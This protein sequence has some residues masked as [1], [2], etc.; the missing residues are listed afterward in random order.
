MKKVLSVML[1]LVML[2]SLFGAFGLTAEAVSVNV[3]YNV[4]LQ[5]TGWQ[6]QKSN[7]STA[8][9]TG[10]SKRIEAIKISVSGLTNGGVMYR[11]YIQNS[12]WQTW[13]TSGSLSGTTGKSLR[14]EAIQI[15]LTGNYA[16][17]YDIVYRVHVQNFGWLSWTK[18]GGTAGTTN[19]SYRMEAIQMKLVKKGSFSTSGSASRTTP[20][21]SYTAHVQDIGW[22]SSKSNGTTAGTTGQAKQMEAIKISCKNFSGKGCIK[23]SAH[24]QDVGWQK[25]VS[26]NT[27]AGTT[28]K[29]KRMEAIKISLDSTMSPYFDVYYRVHISN[30]GWLAWTKNGAIAGSTGISTP[31]EAIQIK[32]VSN[33]DTSISTKGKAY[34]T[35][36]SNTSSSSSLSQ[37]RQKMVNIAYR[38]YNTRTQGM[39]NKYNNYNG[40]SWCKYFVCYVANQAGVPTS[41]ITTNNYRCDETQEWFEKMGRSYAYKSSLN[42]QPGDLVILGNGNVYVKNSKGKSVLQR[43]HIG[44]VV[45]VTSSTIKTIEG[46]TT[47]YASSC[48]NV[49][50]YKRSNGRCGGNNSWGINYVLKP[51]Y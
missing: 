33:A 48:V 22:Q 35:A 37:A 32:V 8:G 30:Y 3:K 1:S 16:S 39:Y 46:N 51:N 42:I 7:G 45:E 11:T 14:A 47:G 50:Y 41:V 23:Y 28:G 31:I 2:C 26:N 6:A 21:I 9:S 25:W 10:N 44:I 20:N 4:H 27:V 40:R 5:D 15:K 43:P 17:K 36:S 13:K 38:E 29:S 18:N 24:V 34:I 19:M 49:K 12:G